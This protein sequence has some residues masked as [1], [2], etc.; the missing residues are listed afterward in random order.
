MVKQIPS[1]PIQKNKKD[2]YVDVTINKAGWEVMEIG[3]V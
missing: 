1:I 3:T 2:P